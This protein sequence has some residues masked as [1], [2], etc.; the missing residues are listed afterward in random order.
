MQPTVT[1]IAKLAR[2][3]LDESEVKVFEERMRGF[4]AMMD[5]LPEL[6]GE[7]APSPESVMTLRA[8]EPQA[9]FGR[10][11]LL[12]NAPVKQAGCFVVPKAV[13]GE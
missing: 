12:E 2:I 13:R 5:T 1:Q 7:L 10:D 9:S 11:K 4:L 3:R 8:D 6:E